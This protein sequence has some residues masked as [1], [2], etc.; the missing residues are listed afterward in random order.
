MSEWPNPASRTLSNL[1]IWSLQVLSPLFWAFQ[2]ISSSLCSW[3]ILFSC[4]LR[5]CSG[6]PQ[7]PIPHWYKPLI[8]FLTLFMS[9]LSPPIPDPAPLSPSLFLL[10]S[11]SFPPYTSDQYF[12][13]PSK[14]DWCILTLIFLYFDL[15]VVCE[16][17][18]VYL[19]FR[20]ILANVLAS[21]LIST[22]Q[23]VHNLGYVCSWLGLPHS[24]WSFL[25]PP[26]CLR[27]SW[28]NHF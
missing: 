28:I 8:K 17:Y 14:K 22:Y 6:Y 11:K 16:L 12:V 23:W 3:S 25:V 7:F 20:L 26:I 24:G 2:L 18:C 1:W 19:A 21:G 5:L 9:S 10:P 15:R 27:I 4:H 13:P